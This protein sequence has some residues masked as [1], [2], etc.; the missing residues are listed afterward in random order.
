M[1]AFAEDLDESGNGE[2][3]TWH[4]VNYVLSLSPAEK[5][6]TL[7]A[8]QVKR[9]EGELPEIPDDENWKDV[10]LSQYPMAGQIIVEPRMFTPKI[11]SVQL[12]A[13]Y[14]QD[15]IAFLLTW[16]DSTE[17]TKTDPDEGSFADAIAFQLPQKQEGLKPYFLNGDSENPTYLLHWSADSEGSITEMNAS[18]MKKMAAQE[19]GKQN[20][21]GAVIYD[22]G[23]YRLLIK[24]SLKTDDQKDAQFEPGKFIPVAF[25]AW[26]GRNGETET[27]RSISAWYFLILEAQIPKIVY[28]YPILAIF[29]VAA[30]EF[31]LISWITKEKKE[32]S[33]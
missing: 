11:D 21:K 3:K 9:I 17:M 15:E 27:K 10:P 22:K 18:G 24:R 20:A 30:F 19:Q 25:S 26:D 12:K 2:E 16:H 31:I 8:Y 6:K 1:P 33:S 4:L 14:N 13:L 23:E 32:A 5:P 29:A 28:Y 7:A